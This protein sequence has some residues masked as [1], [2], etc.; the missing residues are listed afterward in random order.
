MNRMVN[1][2]VG[3]AVALLVGTAGAQ[4]NE[5]TLQVATLEQALRLGDAWLAHPSQ[6]PEPSKDFEHA[7]SMQ[8]VHMD[9]Y[10]K[11][12]LFVVEMRQP[13]AATCQTMVRSAYQQGNRTVSVDGQ[14]VWDPAVAAQACATGHA[15]LSIL[16]HL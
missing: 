5:S 13:Q 7:V 4:V 14:K 6:A 12:S 9:L 3:M 16:S 8:Q 10:P 15:R 1:G 11:S 2:M